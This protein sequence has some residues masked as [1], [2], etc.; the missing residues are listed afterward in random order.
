MQTRYNSVLALALAAALGGTLPG[1]AQE[2]QS[3]APPAA[4]AEPAQPP[5]E[6]Q[7]PT[8]GWHRFGAPAQTVAPLP[9]TLTL[10]AG[11][12]ITVRVDQEISTDR[13]QAGDFFAASLAQPLVADGVVVARR[14][15]TVGGVVAEAQKGGRVKGVSRL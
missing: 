14:G 1:L 3:P 2:S 5:Q 6:A 15:Q 10:P 13:N 9:A 11:T 12:W 4:P 8:T 7:P